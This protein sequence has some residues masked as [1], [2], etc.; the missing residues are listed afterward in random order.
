MKHKQGGGGS[1][2]WDSRSTHD[3]TG[4]QDTAINGIGSRFGDEY[5]NLHRM[6]YPTI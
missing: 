5:D 6:T 4:K 1:C 3:R 2:R